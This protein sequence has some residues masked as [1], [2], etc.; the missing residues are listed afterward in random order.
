MI[1]RPLKNEE[2]DQLASLIHHSTNNWYQRNLNRD[3]FPPDQPA[4]CRVFPEVYE[5]L[6]PGCCLV[7]ELDGTLVGSCFYHPRETH[8]SLGIMNAA[9][10]IFGAAKALLAEVIRLANGKPIRLVSSALNLDSYS[11]YTRAGFTPTAIFQDMVFSSPPTFPESTQETR[12]ALLDDLPDLLQLEEKVSG[13]RREKDLRHFIENQAGI[14]SGSVSL[15]DNKITGFLFSVNHPG[16]KMLGPGIMTSP[17][18]ALA[19]IASQ[20]PRFGNDSPLFLVPAD[21]PELISTLYRLGARNCELHLSQVLGEAK[22]TQGIIMPT[23]M[24]ETG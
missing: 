2:W 14:W 8:V 17:E 22:S 7:A 24:P 21:Q 23:F 6:D 5:A 20:L 13:I 15:S 1:I 11:L 19:L 10:H 18:A 9:P 3:C 12:P 16:S 4:S